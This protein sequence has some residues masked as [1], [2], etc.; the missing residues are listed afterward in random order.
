MLKIKK[1]TLKSGMRVVYVPMPAVK[2]ITT[3]LLVNTG[4]RYEESTEQGLAHLLEH[5]V[6][7]GTQKYPDSLSLSIALDGIGA[8]S[9]AF[10]AKEYTGFYVTAASLHLEFCLKMLRELVFFPLI[11]SEDVEQERAVVIEEIKMHRDS[12]E[13]FIADEFE[14]MVYQGSSLEHPISGSIESVSLQ[15]ASSLQKFLNKWYGLENLTLVIAGDKKVLDENDLSSK[16]DTIFNDKNLFG[17]DEG[18]KIDKRANHHHERRLGFFKENCFSTKKS[19][20]RKR[21]TEQAHLIMGWPALKRDDPQRYVLTVLATVMGGN[22]SS[23]L[24][25]T[26]RE[27]ANLAYYVFADVDQYQDAG[28]LGVSAGLNSKKLEQ[29][30]ELIKNEF[31]QLATNKKPINQE[32]LERAQAYLTGRITLSLESSRAV[33]QHYGLSWLLLNRIDEP[34]DVIKG[35]R[36]VTLDQLQSL[37]P[38]IIKPDELRIAVVSRGK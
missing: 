29:G 32:E 3:L 4:S 30:I 16:I 33:A 34:Q 2:S 26:I 28:L 14:Q 7:R 22:R 36:G 20:K 35:I 6:F 10:T 13:D 31:D 5:L 25:Q 19:I 15:T 17:E 12:P 38:K 21:D 8:S 24:F 18:K 11:R 37:A 27:K 9:N 23:R 1:Q